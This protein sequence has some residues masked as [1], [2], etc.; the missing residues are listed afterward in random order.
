MNNYKMDSMTGDNMSKR[1]I[2]NI[3]L[4]IIMVISIFV[5]S[6]SSMKK[7]DKEVNAAENLKDETAAIEY[8]VDTIENQENEAIENN[9][10]EEFRGVW[11]SS[12]FNLDYPSKKTTDDVTLKNEAIKILDNAEDM[13]FNAVLLQV[14]PSSDAIYPS[15]IFPWSQFLTGTQGLAPDNN[16]D[17]LEFFIEEAHKRGIELHAWINP[18]RITA[19]PSFNNMLASNNPAVLH[20]ELTVLHTDGK[21]YFNPGE[22]EARQ[23]IIDGIKEILDNYDVDGIHIDDYFYPG[24]DFN[25]AETYAKYGQGFADINDWRRNNNNLLIKEISKT[26]HNKDTELK[27]GVSP[28]GIWANKKT[29]Q[30]GSQTSGWETYSNQFADSRLW[31]KEGYVDYIMP[32]IWTGSL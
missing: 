9:N 7:Q 16:F 14:K 27:F 12:V 15:K 20:P 32:Q 31:V 23:L 30:L 18:Y 25:D 28:S 5:L 26:V 24:K 4:L 21:L 2:S 11:V 1:I 17:P 19:D 3:T 8:K 22:P 29:S 6:Q 10:V 13:G